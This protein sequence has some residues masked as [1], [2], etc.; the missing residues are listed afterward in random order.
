MKP[1]AVNNS[2][3]SAQQTLSS[4]LQLAV[5]GV[6][7]GALL[8]QGTELSLAVQVLFVGLLL[9]LIGRTSA[10]PLLVAFQLVLFF[11]ETKSSSLSARFDTESSLFVLIVLGLLMF[12]SRDQTLKRFSRRS[13]AELA[14]SLFTGWS[15]PS[16]QPGTVPPSSLRP[17]V[18]GG[19]LLAMS[20]LISQMVLTQLSLPREVLRGQPSYEAMKL[21]LASAP[22]LLT[23][24]IATV[25]VMSWLSWCRLTREQASMYGRSTLV[26]QLYA[27]LNL[28]VRHQLR[29][30]RRNRN[31]AP[32]N[33]ALEIEQ[34][35]SSKE[36]RQNEGAQNDEAKKH[37]SF[38]LS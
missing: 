15:V 24:L 18:Q 6:L 30:R 23:G 28:I 8:F 12:L 3:E 11:R 14:R 13:V 4:L 17:L 2:H 5:V 33:V 35:I 36:V 29:W 25:I 27:D 31:A 34:A 22:T 9:L 37:R 1:D 20:V 38:R 21:E 19:M 32:V 7:I 26:T 10:A 16:T